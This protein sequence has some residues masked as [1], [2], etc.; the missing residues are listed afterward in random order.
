LKR[1]NL[2]K[3]VDLLHENIAV[4]PPYLI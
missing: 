2:G 1:K 4:I 3:F